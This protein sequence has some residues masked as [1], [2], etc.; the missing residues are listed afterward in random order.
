MRRVRLKPESFARLDAFMRGAIY[1]MWKAGMKRKDMLKGITKKDGTVPDIRAIDGAIAK[2]KAD[3]QWRG[4]ESVAGGRPKALTTG[5]VKRL[6]ALV[7]NNV[8]RRR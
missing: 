2:F 8:A 1:G 4:E 3:P 6:V 7:S 5:Q